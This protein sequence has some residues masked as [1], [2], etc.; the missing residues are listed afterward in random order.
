MASQ[1]V[2]IPG[3]LIGVSLLFACAARPLPGAEAAR[4]QESDAAPS[5]AASKRPMTSTRVTDESATD[6][7]ETDTETAD[8]RGAEPAEVTSPEV[9]S[10]VPTA[11]ES[12]LHPLDVLTGGDTAFLIDYANS[13]AKERAERTCLAQARSEGGMTSKTSK[14][15]STSGDAP[16]S[17]SSSGHDESDQ[18]D[19]EKEAEKVRERVQTCLTKERGKFTADVLRF[20]RDDRGQGTF[21][22]YRRAGSALPEVHVARVSYEEVDTHTVKVKVAG[23]VNGARPICRDQR[24]LEVKIPNGYSIVLQDPVYGSLTYEAKIGLVAR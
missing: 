24:D 18:K 15:S 22:V 9:E 8:V 3:F 6:S 13:D 7:K 23:N 17:A 14:S 16:S 19:D 2:S 1:S 21:T 20:R 5:K 10:P 12:P 4:R 11:T